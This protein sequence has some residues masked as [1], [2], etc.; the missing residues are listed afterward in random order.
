[1]SDNFFSRRGFLRGASAMALLSGFSGCRM[2]GCAGG[3]KPTR[4]VV[5][6]CPDLSGDFDWPR[7][8][9]EAGL[10]TIGTHFGP[11]DVMPFLKSAKGRRFLDSCGERGIEVEHE[12]HALQYLLPR[13]RFGAEK[14][15]FR[16]NGKGERVCD[17]NCCVTNPR[18]LEIISARAVEVARVC[19]STTGRYY[20]WLA[21]GKPVCQCPKC[22]EF[23]AADQSVIV[24]NAIVKALRAEID[25]AATLSHLAYYHTLM[26]PTK[27]KPHEALFLEFAPIKRWELTKRRDPLVEGGK[28]LRELD[29]LLKV[30][31][32]ET[33]QILEYWL[34]ESLFS[35]W[36]RP[37]VK[38]PWNGPLTREE[39]KA[40]AK[41]GIRHFTTFGVYLGDEY[42][43]S[44]GPDFVGPV[45]E[46]AKIL[47]EETQN[48]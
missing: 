27:V 10:T 4:G 47:A 15:L 18:A 46:Y 43:R 38:M 48:I 2:F 23:S 14:E 29:A 19:R 8:A 16:M 5:L 45:K 25:P 21:D 37:Y 22:R 33:A 28:D 34:D 17:G 6:G 13:E 30:F 26:P 9:Q 12:L 1:M 44:H 36:K 11:G 31:P 32:V 40:Y 42:I 35:G 20:Y 7:L 3:L 41:R 24:E 39:V